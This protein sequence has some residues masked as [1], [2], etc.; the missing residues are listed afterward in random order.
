[1]SLTMGTG[2]FGVRPAGRFNV[3]LPRKNVVYVE[4]SPRRIRGEL[5]GETIVDSRHAKLVHEHGRIPSYY[6]PEDEVRMDL[7]ERSGRTSPN[8]NR[9]E[10]AHWTLRAG[11]RVV[12][13]AAWSH[14]EPAAGV[15]ALAGHLYFEWHALD[16]W[17]EEEEPAI[18][19]ARDPYHRVDVLPTSRRVRVSVDGNVLAESNRALVIYETGLPPRWYFRPE[20]VDRDRLEA[21]D[22][23]TGCAYKGFA[24][25]WSLKDAGDEGRALAWYYPEP[26]REVEPIAGRVAFFDE[27]VD[28]EV[29]GELQER[30][31]TPW[32]RPPPAGQEERPPV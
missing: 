9:G 10:A 23:R 28:L 20:D 4:D 17:W 2:P 31:K 30:P 16:R 21:S 5:E 7:L 25:Y 15:E 22:H 26:R 29:D 14:P 8:P 19:H 6:F 24:S 1:M 18:V 12:E 32:S 11:E 27:R 13:D 3:D